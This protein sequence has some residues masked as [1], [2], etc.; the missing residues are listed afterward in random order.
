LIKNSSSTYPVN[1][2]PIGD[3]FLG[4]YILNN[5]GAFS[6]TLTFYNVGDSAGKYYYVAIRAFDGVN[7]TGNSLIKPN[8]NWTGA[9]T[10]ITYNKQV[11]VSSGSGINVSSTLVVTPNSRITITPELPDGIPAKLD[12]SI[13]INNGSII[14][15]NSTFNGRNNSTGEFSINTR[16][17]SNP[18]IASDNNGNFVVTSHS[19]RDGSGYGVYA[20]RYNSLG[21]PQ[22]SE[23]RVNS[24]TNDNQN[25][26]SITSDNNG[27]FIITWQSSS[28]DGSGDGVYAQ[29]YNNL[30]IPQGSEFRV[31]TYTT[32]NQNKPSISIDKNGNFII[33][34]QSSSQDGSGYGVYAQ[35]Y[36][37][38][39]IPQGSEFRV[40]TYTT[41]NQNKPSISIDKNGNFAVAWASEQDGSYYGIYSQRYNSL[42]VPQGSEFRVNSYT[43]YSQRIPTIVFD[44]NNNFIITWESVQNYNEGTDIF[45]QRYNSLGVPQGSEF[46]VNTYT[47]NS[48]RTPKMATDSSGN[49]VVTWESYFQDGSH[50]GIYAQRYNSL[51]VPQGSEFQVHT[52]T[53]YYQ[54]SPSL[55]MDSNGNFVITWSSTDFKS[56]LVGI[57]AQRYSSLGG[58]K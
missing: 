29:R 52:Y 26:P 8:S 30:G 15:S 46:R 1:G 58:A 54:A 42:G 16:L 27:N 22:G 53:S 47:T 49:F 2:D 6:S 20:Q 39:G 55:A 4:P 14:P 31:N 57:Y 7:A 56:N 34:W 44:I 48:Q 51:G 41:S 17:S 11:T 18:S 13:N 35:R 9:T 33:T 40:N 38:L 3:K 19:Q 37:N 36:N 50:G 45:I 10:N 12:T 23:F 28:Q 43:T 32:S 5:N 25:N 24:Y 21:V